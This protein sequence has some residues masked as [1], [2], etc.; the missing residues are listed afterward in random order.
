MKKTYII[1]KIV[2]LCETS[3]QKIS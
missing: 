2:A 1:F 3:H